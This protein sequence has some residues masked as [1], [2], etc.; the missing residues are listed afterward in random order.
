MGELRNNTSTLPKLKLRH[1]GN[2]RTQV[3][4]NNINNDDGNNSDP[5][6]DIRH[7]TIS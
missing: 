2:I 6:V 4:A 5:S 7:C 3:G 1:P